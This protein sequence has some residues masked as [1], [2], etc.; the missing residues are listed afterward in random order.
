MNDADDT[1]YDF[2]GSMATSVYD[3]HGNFYYEHTDTIID[4][5][6]SYTN[7]GR[8]HNHTFFYVQELD[9]KDPHT[10]RKWYR[11]LRLQDGVGEQDRKQQNRKADRERWARTFCSKVDLTP[12]QTEEVVWT[13]ANISF[14][15]FGPWPAEVVILGIM[16][17]V[18]GRDGR[19]LEEEPEFQGLMI[20]MEVTEGSLIGIRNTVRIKVDGI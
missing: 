18:A 3:G 15:G 12:Y 10:I 2:S 19:I 16:S 5:T 8:S 17:L 1:N 6:S 13:C 20:D 11:M 14:R 4:E 9:S 7:D